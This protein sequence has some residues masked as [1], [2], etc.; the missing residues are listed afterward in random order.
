MATIDAVAAVVYTALLYA[1]AHRLE[2]MN[3]FPVD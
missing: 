2:K 1:P 3:N